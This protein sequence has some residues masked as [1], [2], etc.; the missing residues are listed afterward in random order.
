MRLTIIWCCV[1]FAS[2]EAS[3]YE[4]HTRAFLPD[5][6]FISNM[7]HCSFHDRYVKYNRL[8]SGGLA[9]IFWQHVAETGFGNTTNVQ[10]EHCLNDLLT[11][12]NNVKHGHKEQYYYIDSASSSPLG[13]LEGTV[14]NFGDFDQ[15]MQL[16]EKSQYCNMHLYLIEKESTFEDDHV[17]LT[18][19]TIPGLGIFQSLCLPQ[20]CSTDDIKQLVTQAIYCLPLH[21]IP[22]MQC[23][24]MGDVDFTSKVSH[25]SRNQKIAIAVLTIS[26]VISA[27][28]TF[29]GATHGIFGYFNLTQVNKDIVMSKAVTDSWLMRLN[30][31]YFIYVGVVAHALFC[32]ESPRFPAMMTKQRKLFQMLKSPIFQAFSGAE[33]MI[34]QLGFYSGLSMFALIERSQRTGT[35]GAALVFQKWVRYVKYNRLISGGLADIFWQHVAETGFGNTTNVQNEHCLNDLLTIVNNVKHG[36]K[37]QY[38]YIDSASSSP[39]GYLEGT[40]ANFGDFDQCMQLGEKSQYCNMHLYLVEKE[41]TFE[42]DHVRLTNLTIPGLSIFQSLCLPQACSTDDIKQL[43]PQAIS[44]L[45]LHLIPD[46]QC[47]RVSDVDFASKVA[48]I[49]TS[50]TIAIA[51]LSILLVTSTVSTFFGANS[52]FYGCFNLKQVNEDMLLAKTVTDSWTVRLNKLCFVYLGIVAHAAVCP[53]SPRFFS[54]L[55]KQRKFLQILTNPII[56]AAFGAECTISQ[57]GF[58]SGLSMFAPIE[59]SY[60]SGSSRISLVFEK[61][62]R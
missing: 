4:K 6:G 41:S 60:R 47:D 23:D 13:Y 25:M 17:R 51:I 21:L 28:S 44:C 18:N 57:L 16:G 37:E 49:S 7:P 46:M 59:R 52:G 5:N 15:C 50:Q 35:S 26:L 29:V 22:D 33:S 2:C 54:M 48:N 43:V 1:I 56:Q 38:H 39:L 14:A 55:T 11:I 27:W 32:P 36:H 31:L 53:E 61:W 20:A 3:F 34:A 12:V 42:D 58:F 40:L 10:N 24:R 19:L 62:F 30:K 8:I 45:P 9:D